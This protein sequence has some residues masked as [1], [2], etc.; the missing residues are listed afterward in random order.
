LTLPSNRDPMQSAKHLSRSL[1]YEGYAL[2]PPRPAASE[3][4]RPSPASVIYPDW[5]SVNH[6]GQSSVMR[7]ECTIQDDR[8]SAL[9]VRVCFLQPWKLT[10]F[11]SYGGADTNRYRQVGSIRVDRDDYR[12]GEGG[13]ER[14]VSIGPVAMEELLDKG[15]RRNISCGGETRTKLLTQDGETVGK[16]VREISPLEGEVHISCERVPQGESGLR[17]FLRVRFRL[18][19]TTKTGE[20]SDATQEEVLRSSFHACHAVFRVHGGRFLATARDQT[21]SWPVLLRRQDDIVLSSPVFFSDYPELG[22]AGEGPQ[23]D[24]AIEECILAHLPLLTEHERQML[25]KDPKLRAILERAEGEGID[26]VAE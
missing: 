6:D 8:S 21:Q 16:V 13:I 18:E 3:A 9:E 4:R 26:A 17:P 23:D 25:T 22:K 24:P 12:P 5:W 11:Q 1:L 19:N 15:V 14:E 10:V 7:T 20:R 2:F